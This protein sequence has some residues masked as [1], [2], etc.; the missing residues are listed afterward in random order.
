MGEGHPGLQSAPI[1]PR[2]SALFMPAS[3]LRAQ[4][5]AR[6]LAADAVILDLE[7]AVGPDD[8][9][10]ARDMA[11]AAVAAGGFGPRELVVRING[12]DTPWGADDLAALARAGPDAILVPKVSAPEDIAACRRAIGDGVRLW[13]MIE[14]LPAIFALDALGLASAGM[15]VDVWVIG[16]NDLAKAMGCRPGPDR[17]PLLPAL[18]MSIM[19]ARAHGISI[20]DGVYNEIPDLE[21]LARECAQGSEYGFD[22][23][24]LIHPSHLEAANRA[25]APE[26]Q[27]LEW[28]RTVARAFD[29]PENAGRGVVKVEGRMVERLHLDEALRT[30]ALAQAIAEREA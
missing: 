7:D 5:K 1:R 25:F 10:T 8:K 24:S 22:G 2:R 11:V 19:A 3:N 16:T 27:A 17:A 28:A 13:A 26:P 30:L 9:A 21:G 29:S 6:T 4:E 15:G 12:L 18:A 20:L 14:T 23:K